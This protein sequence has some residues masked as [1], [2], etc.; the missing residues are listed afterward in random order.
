MKDE[1]IILSSFILILFFCLGACI[2]H[3]NSGFDK[4][5]SENEYYNTKSDNKVNLVFYKAG[6]PYCKAGK[7]EVTNQ[8]KKSKIVTYFIN[9]ESKKGL[10]IAKRYHVKYA[11]TIVAIR[12]NSN[13]SFLYAHDKGKKIVVEK[14]KIK[15]VFRS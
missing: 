12:K 14:N 9:V 15:E 6:C 10:E 8:A 11:P 3:W 7:N 1:K 2:Y 5:L 13:K 4:R